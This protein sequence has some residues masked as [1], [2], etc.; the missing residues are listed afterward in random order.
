MASKN[1]LDCMKQLQSIGWF[2]D[3][4]YQTQFIIPCIK[5]KTFD[6][7]FIVDG[8]SY[9]V[10]IDGEQHFKD[11]NHWKSLAYKQ[12]I[13]DCMKQ[14]VAI[15]SNYKVIRIHHQ[16]T[17]NFLLHVHAAI[18]YFSSN[19]LQH[20]YYSDPELY[21]WMHTTYTTTVITAKGHIRKNYVKRY[22]KKRFIEEFCEAEAQ[23]YPIFDIM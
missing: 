7:S 23:F 19:P 20:V 5:R 15:A 8:I 10:E 2:K 13:N 21:S 6:F 11:V 18:Q 12:H 16:H 9:V 22:V 3:I 17:K 14:I 4:N 1:E